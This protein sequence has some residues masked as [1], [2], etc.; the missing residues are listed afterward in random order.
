MQPQ[1]LA[2]LSRPRS[3]GVYVRGQACFTRPMRLASAKPPTCPSVRHSSIAPGALER[4]TTT[5]VDT[6]L[7]THQDRGG[8]EWLYS[9]TFLRPRAT[10][11]VQYASCTVGLGTVAYG[12]ATLSPA[13]LLAMAATTALGAWI[14]HKPAVVE[15][16][17]AAGLAATL[18]RHTAAALRDVQH[19]VAAAA[20]ATA[21]PTLV[22]A[23]CHGPLWGLT[24]G[25]G[26]MVAIAGYASRCAQGLLAEPTLWPDR[27]AYDDISDLEGGRLF[28]VTD[29]RTGRAVPVLELDACR[30]AAAGFAH[31]FALG[32]Q[33]NQLLPR[34]RHSLMLQP[35]ANDHPRVVAK[36]CAQ[37]TAAEIAEMRGMAD[38][39]NAWAVQ[40]K[41]DTRLT[42]EDVVGVQLMPDQCHF[43]WQLTEQ[44][45]RADR[46][47]SGAPGLG[48]A[49]AQADN[50]AST[51]L[52]G[53]TSI[54]YRAADAGIVLGRNMDWPACG[55]AGSMSLV[56]VWKDATKRQ[57]FATLGVP[58]M[59]GCVTGWNS[60]GL[61]LAMNVVGGFTS[62]VDGVPAAI[63]NRRMLQ[64]A[65]STSEVLTTVRDTS[66]PQPLGPYHMIVGDPTEGHR[67]SF[68]QGANRSHH[69][70][71]LSAAEPLWCLN[72]T[73]PD[74]RCDVHNSSAR[75]R[76]FGRILQ[77]RATT[78]PFGYRACRTR[79]SR[80]VTARE[81]Q[82]P[83][84]AAYL[85][86]CRWPGRPALEQRLCGN[87]SAAYYCAS[88]RL[89]PIRSIGYA[90]NR[91]PDN[92]L[93]AAVSEAVI[94]VVQMPLL[95]VAPQ[96]GGRSQHPL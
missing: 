3:S 32:K 16:M 47:G 50:P 10:R 22:G 81:R 6:Y 59:M 68:Y 14:Y 26:A 51:S 12:V 93:G 19:E 95:H 21:A 9:Q 67:I 82:W 75:D 72:W 64:T 87:P 85:G 70:D 48:R 45:L 76:D 58:A 86:V 34:F 44:R 1:A 8:I 73:Y 60:R 89:A 52:W 46:D 61:S 7:A 94:Q 24:M 31:G 38:G 11:A 2:Y 28:H 35:N 78:W 74:N 23:F 36:L 39:F 96:V 20:V 30:P 13:G 91:T 55:E 4:E 88:R 17:L 92:A 79:D 84:Y 90:H 66:A 57:A 37:L 33:I 25:A 83:N 71:A 5:F 18:G 56:M 53:C 42:F 27:S 49:T 80:R 69:I 77:G 41:S 15:A 63:Y 40:A 62:T 54:L 65:A 43:Q 29:A